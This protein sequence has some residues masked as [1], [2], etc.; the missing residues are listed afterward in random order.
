M[1]RRFCRPPKLGGVPSISAGPAPRPEAGAAPEGR[2]RIAAIHLPWAKTE[3]RRLTGA[4]AI[5]TTEGPR[6]LLAAVTPEAAAAGLH[7]GQ[8]LADAQ[9]ILPDLALHSDEPEAEA[10]W[11]RRLGLWALRF[12]PLP[13]LDPPDGLLLEITGVAHLHGGE[14]GLQAALAARFARAGLT[15]QV[16]IA[17]TAEAAAA[18]ARNGGAPPVPPGGEAAAIAPLPLAALRLPEEAIATFHRLGLRR[19]GEVL[20]QPRAPLA[21]RFGP[22]VMGLLDAATGARPRPLQPLQPPPDC[23][24]AEEFLEPLVTREAIDAALDRLL[25]ALC[26]RLEAAGLGARRLV[27]R[28]FRVDGAVQ[29]I[30][31]GTGLPS[32][33]PRHFARLFRERLEKLE[34][35]FGFDR[36]ALEAWRTA[37][38]AATQGA[39]PGK[40]G[41]G[42]EQRAEALAELLD[43]L[44]QRLPVWRLAPQASHWPEREVVR[45]GPFDPVAIPPGWPSPGRPIRLLR[46]PVELSA[47]AV[48]P[49]APPSLLRA[50]RL[51]WRVLRAEGPERITPE[52]WR[53]GP[54]RLF[55]DYY[56]V[57]LAGGAR[58]WVCRAGPAGPGMRWWLHGRFA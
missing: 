17:G 12:T 56:R 29:E 35:G 31:V 18:L 27:L 23:E 49:D 24:A 55:R 14:A 36:L 1:R 45:V 57:E 3:R 34:P 58:L 47:I 8:A 41:P 11:L 44:S 10:A 54:E 32:R 22:A 38:L 39:L 28:G 7:P 30:P 20:R 25:A 9:A 4:A 33:A 43:R 5:W 15:A 52:W 6:R 19:L 46:R 26:A 2:R 21:R 50:G 53:D 42:P 16:A 13:A 51:S 37:P 48:M 40:A